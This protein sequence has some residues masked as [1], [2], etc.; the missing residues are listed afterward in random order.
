[1]STPKVDPFEQR[2][3]EADIRDRFGA[4]LW[5]TVY[6]NDGKRAIETHLGIHAY[7]IPVAHLPAFRPHLIGRHTGERVHVDIAP[8]QSQHFRSA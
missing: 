2:E 7:L 5:T 6:Y 4:E 3:F 1:M 8:R